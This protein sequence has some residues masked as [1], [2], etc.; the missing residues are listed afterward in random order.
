MNSGHTYQTHQMHLPPQPAVNGLTL[1]TQPFETQCQYCM[2]KVT[3]R[4][5]R[6]FGCVQ[7]TVCTVC[8]LIGCVPCCIIPFFIDDMRETVHRCPRCDKVLGRRLA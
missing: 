5:D 6:E 3:T 7:Y 2:N 1:H 4:V 8:C